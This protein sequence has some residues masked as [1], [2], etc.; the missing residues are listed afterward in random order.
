MTYR[1]CMQQPRPMIE[2]KMV[3]HLKNMSEEEIDSYDF[4]ACKHL[5]QISVLCS[6]TLL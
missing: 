1:Y 4:L 2:S 5:H 3:K 6:K